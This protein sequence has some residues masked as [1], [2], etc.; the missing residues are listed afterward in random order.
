MEVMSQGS[1][2]KTILSTLDPIKSRTL[3][4]LVKEF[5]KGDSQCEGCNPMT[6]S[7]PVISERFE[8]MEVVIDAKAVTQSK[9]F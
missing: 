4:I 1:T 8:S 5:P 3:N 6:S 2:S 7:N 9:N